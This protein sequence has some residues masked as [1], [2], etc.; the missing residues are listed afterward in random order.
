MGPQ[1]HGSPATERGATPALK[2]SCLHL[3]SPNCSEAAHNHGAAVQPPGPGTP[4]TTA[5]RSPDLGCAPWRPGA[6][7]SRFS[8]AGSRRLPSPSGS[9]A[10]GGVRRPDPG[11]SLLQTPWPRPYPAGSQAE[12]HCRK[13]RGAEQRSRGSRGGEQGSARSQ[14]PRS[15]APRQRPRALL[16]KDASP[17]QSKAGVKEWP[18]LTSGRDSW[19]VLGAKAKL[20]LDQRGRSRRAWRGKWGEGLLGWN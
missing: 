1:P 7:G 18:R 13:T 6:P 20:D 14:P 11:P 3:V 5:S 19:A 4:P 12:G 17:N 15:P 9:L 10:S 8:S 2:T 16:A